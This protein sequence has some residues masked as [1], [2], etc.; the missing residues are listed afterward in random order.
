M[1]NLPNKY[2]ANYLRSPVRSVCKNDLVSRATSLYNSYEFDI[3]RMYGYPVL[4]F[5]NMYLKNSIYS[6]SLYF[7]NH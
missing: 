5:K 7:L 3:C 2:T 6:N 1:E 4:K